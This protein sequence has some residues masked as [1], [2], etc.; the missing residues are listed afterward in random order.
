MDETLKTE[1]LVE[2]LCVKVYH[3]VCIDSYKGAF[4]MCR[5]IV[6]VKIM[7]RANYNV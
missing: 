1:F 2:F 6:I 7:I 4:K 5:N 3:L